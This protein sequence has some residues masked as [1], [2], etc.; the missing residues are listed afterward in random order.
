MVISVDGYADLSFLVLFS[1]PLSVVG[2][3]CSGDRSISFRNLTLDSW[4]TIGVPRLDENRNAG[5]FAICDLSSDSIDFHPASSS[6]SGDGNQE[7]R[8]SAHVEVLY[9]LE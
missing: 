8:E 9:G 4:Q 2:S 1:V 7:G 3:S 6:L 5:D